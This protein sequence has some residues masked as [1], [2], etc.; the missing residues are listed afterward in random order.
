MI[1][2]PS[3]FTSLEGCFLSNTVWSL[4]FL[5]AF[6]GGAYVGSIVG[7]DEGAT[8]GSV[9]AAGLVGF[10]PWRRWVLQGLRKLRRHLDSELGPPAP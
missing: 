9:T 8:F 2:R 6:T 10:T 3:P 1:N 4:M 7:G 5:I